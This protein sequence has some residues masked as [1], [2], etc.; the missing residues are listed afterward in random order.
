MSSSKK[1][2]QFKKQGESDITGHNW[3]FQKKFTRHYWTLLDIINIKINVI[4]FA[5]DS[6]ELNDGIPYNVQ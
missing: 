4:Y 5:F 1:N 3:T 6:V 2:V